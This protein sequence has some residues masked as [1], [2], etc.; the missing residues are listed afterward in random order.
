VPDADEVL[1]ATYRGAIAAMAMSGMRAFTV[2]AGLVRETPP[3][4]I[5][6]RQAPG[7][8]SHVPRAH[9]RAAIEVAHWGYG[10]GGGAAFGMLPDEVR[11]TRWSGVVFGLALWA[12]FELGIAPVLGLKHAKRPRAAELAALAADHALY[13]L[14][15]SETRAR[16]RE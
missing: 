15:L 4:A 2:H 5:F 3:R 8:L 12:G 9:R 6:R 13:G 11:R 1:H 10:A 14:V 7:L 16:P